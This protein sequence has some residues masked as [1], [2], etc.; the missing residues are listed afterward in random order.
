V[1]EISV[2]ENASISSVSEYVSTEP[3]G[4]EVQT[5]KQARLDLPQGTTSLQVVGQGRDSEEFATGL[6]EDYGVT[7][8]EPR[9]GLRERIRKPFLNRKKNHQS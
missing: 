2:D 7:P 9:T 1:T 8:E 5:S 4:I 3:G 6:K